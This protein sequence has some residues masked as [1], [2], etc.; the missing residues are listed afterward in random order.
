MTVEVITATRHQSTR[1]IG[2]A[3]AARLLERGH[4]AVSE[5]IAVVGELE[6]GAAVVIGSP[7][8]MGKWVRS[9]R[10]L[11]AR[12]AAEAPGRP[13]WAFSVGPLGDPPEP[14]G[15][16]PGEEIERFVAERA[17][18]HRL[19]SGRLDLARLSRR[20][21]LV[22]RTIKAPEGDFRDWTVIEAWT[23]GIADSLA[24]A[25]PGRAPA[26]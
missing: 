24:R 22:V 26:G 11:A 6:P 12:L 14:A 15:A 18:E 19:F 2:D 4:Q 23:D 10:A 17:I 21:R 16:G 9:A 1:E 13:I 5:D 20:E 8:Y 7:I 3:I 25:D